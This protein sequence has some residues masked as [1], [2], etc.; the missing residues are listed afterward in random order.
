MQNK[1]QRTKNKHWTVNLRI[2]RNVSIHLKMG[3]NSMLPNQGTQLSIV[4]R[5]DCI[6][7]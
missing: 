3:L 7:L 5:S 2:D 1:E 6:N 4:Q